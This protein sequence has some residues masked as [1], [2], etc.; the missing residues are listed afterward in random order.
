MASLVSL[1]NELK[2]S[3]FE[4][5]SCADFISLSGTCRELHIY[6]LP[7]A[8]RNLTLTWANINKQQPK[9]PVQHKLLRTI[10]QKPN[11]ANSI[12]ALSIE[13]VGC[14]GFDDNDDLET[15]IPGSK[16]KLDDE[17]E[18]MVHGLIVELGLSDD[19]EWVDALEDHQQ[20][21]T[22][23]AMVLAQC[24]KLESLDLSVVFFLENDWFEEMIRQGLI[25]G[26]GL[27]KWMANLKHLRLTCDTSGDEWTPGGLELEET[28]RFPFY[29]PTLETLEFAR[30]EIE[31]PDPDEWQ[32]NQ[33]GDLEGYARW[34]WPY[35]PE[36]PPAAT[37][38]TTL[39]LMRASVPTYALDVILRQTPNLSTFHL[40][41]FLEFGL[42]TFDLAA[43]KAAL[44]RVQ[45]TLAHL[46]VR[47]E[48]YQNDGMGEE[49]T[50]GALGPFRGY[51]ALTHLE[52]TL[53]ALIGFEGEEYI[54]SN[55]LADLL[56]PNLL[57]LTITDDLWMFNS[58][59]GRFEDIEAMA[60]FRRYLTGEELAGNWN[61]NVRR[62][63][64]RRFL[65][66]RWVPGAADGG[67]RTATPLLKKFVYDLRKRGYLSREYWNKG[68]IRKQFRNMCKQQGLEGEVLWRKIQYA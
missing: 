52:V 15:D 41:L 5:L 50:M 63:W 26:S 45:P 33:E 59:L 55:E 19:E 10:I 43:L 28:T 48:D 57:S 18:T 24:T 65:T 2:D 54:E 7:L 4:H 27:S 68:M 21:Y 34:F 37:N 32:N 13:A 46:T 3:I 6:T 39:R 49:F 35:S 30:F 14:V 64:E 23:M 38:L 42:C 12:K 40:D 56:P 20:F 67:W 36:I 25:A 17:D 31:F 16:I 9:A 66:V 47:F 22:V 62:N 58:Y 53:H 61:E 29:L 44:D 11:Y 8:Y 51:L 60:I 1:P